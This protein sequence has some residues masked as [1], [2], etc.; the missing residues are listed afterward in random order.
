MNLFQMTGVIPLGTPA[1][2]V[3]RRFFSVHFDCLNVEASV[4]VESTSV[5]YS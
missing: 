4:S 5:M 1:N 2:G 3:T